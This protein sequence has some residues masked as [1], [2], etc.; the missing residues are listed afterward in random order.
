MLTLFT[1]G[2]GLYRGYDYCVYIPGYKPTYTTPSAGLAPATGLSSES[3]LAEATMVGGDSAVETVSSSNEGRTSRAAVT[4]TVK[5]SG[6]VSLSVGAAG[7][8]EQT[9]V[10]ILQEH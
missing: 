7:F 3:L 4:P 8:R 5:A 1:P 6:T 2:S 10:P 9:L